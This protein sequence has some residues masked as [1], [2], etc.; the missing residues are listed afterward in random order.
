M[1]LGEFRLRGVLRSGWLLA[2]LAAAVLPVAHAAEDSG[3]GAAA[4]A[5]SVKSDGTTAI[6]AP[7]AT[8]KVETPDAA[9]PWPSNETDLPGDPAL[10]QGVLENGLHYALLHNKEPRGRITLRLV[11]A[12]G[13]LQ[14]REDE[15]GIAHFVEH[16]VFRG[17][18][19]HPGEALVAELQRMG[20]GFG[21]ESAAFTNYDHTI[22]HLELPDTTP[23]TLKRGL[24][25]LREYAEE[26]VFDPR[27]IEIERGVVLSE[28]ATRDTGDYRGGVSNLNFLWP[29]SL[30]ARRPVIG[31]EATIRAFTRGQLVAFYD[32]WYRPG[33]LAVVAV[34][35]AD[36][37][38]MRQQVGDVFR[39]LQPRAPARQDPPDLLAS[40]ATPPDIRVFRDP[41]NLG[42]GLSFEH[43][44]PF[45]PHTLS[46]AE[47]IRELHQS[48]AFAMFQNRLLRVA[49][50]AGDSLV[51][52][53]VGIGSPVLGWRLASFS[54][55]SSVASWKKLAAAI[56][57]EHRRAFR[58]GFGE[59]ELQQ[60]R[61]VF[62][63]G[64]AVA[65]RTAP[66]RSS[67]WVASQLVGSLLYGEPFR[68]PEALRDD[69]AGPLEAVT[70][71]ECLS[72]FRQAWETGPLHVFVSTNGTF[73]V[74]TSEIAEVLNQSR[75]SPV[76]PAPELK[77]VKLAYEDF[78]R[79]GVLAQQREIK[80]LDIR[81][82]TFENGVRL[83]FKPTQFNADI[84]YFQ[85]R[86][87]G[88][89]LSQPKSKPALGLLGQLTLLDAGLGRHS[90]EELRD[91]LAAHTLR[92]SFSVQDD[93]FVF[94]GYATRRDFGLAMNLVAAYCTDAAFGEEALRNAAASYNTHF[95]ALE[96]APGGPIQMAAERTL[97]EDPRFGFP[98]R[99]EFYQ[100]DLKGVKA[101]LAPQLASAAMEI[102]VSG[103]DT[104]EDV[105]AA[106]AR[107]LGALPKRMAWPDY[108][109]SE[110][111]KFRARRDKPYVYVTPARLKQTTLAWYWPVEDAGDVHRDRR[112][113][114]L[115]DVLTERLRVRLREE[116]GSA[117]SPVADYIEHDALSRVNY[118]V[119]YAEVDSA[120]ARQAA[121]ILTAEI[122]SLRKDGL[123]EDEFERVK[124]PFVRNRE[125]DILT[126]E[127]WCYTV[128]RMAQ[129]RP[130]T[131]EA[132]RDRQS[133][134][135]SIKR[136]DVERLLYR[137]VNPLKGYF[138][139]AEPGT[140]GKWR[141]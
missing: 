42:V 92:F 49:R 45:S 28:M 37:E 87:A 99:S 95:S 107:S 105:S 111:P 128:L 10:R 21:P 108:R 55:A 118:L 81:L 7:A 77:R 38:L 19:G 133:D 70:P 59:N 102:S 12:A 5:A 103:D 30:Y 31:T 98:W 96:A 65:V 3:L 16:M 120:K 67:P 116:L 115:G 23:A 71:Q 125:D 126:N 56:E 123:T 75:K 127:Y 91:L 109:K 36:P 25:L 1:R 4:A 13:S 110:L 72:A 9:G 106:V 136:K 2:L 32:A 85:V 48:L 74:S 22:Y 117:Y 26:V 33:R 47:R 90:P 57:L 83:N 80:D 82:A 41:T 24:S 88:G 40:S 27:A 86:I 34:G 132:A 134:N 15:R 93:A 76:T 114:L 79:P 14:E 11:V 101:W 100:Q 119:L 46:R 44:R 50:E 139:V 29:D 113:H 18:R 97:L 53:S 94:A 135:A 84:V 69:M 130:A 138:L 131:L 129:R 51:S 137:Y 17:T 124:R 54:A 8:P 122:E 20:L 60:A 78:G 140:A 89:R 35:D 39:T 121:K 112:L 141:K 62:R 73:T 6:A 68:T 61:D 64:Y 104:W 58:F 63:E 43:P 52:P 66:S